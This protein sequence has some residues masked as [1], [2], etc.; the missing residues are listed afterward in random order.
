MAFKT[1]QY[2]RHAKYGN[3]TIVELGVDRT[4]VD[5]DAFGTKKFVTS[6]ATFEAAEGE[7]P[8]RKRSSGSRR[9]KGVAAKVVA[10]KA[11]AK[12]ASA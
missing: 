9:T 6:L 12:A 10:T 4:V 7:A 5:F 2:I 8:K 3:G 1:G 11:L